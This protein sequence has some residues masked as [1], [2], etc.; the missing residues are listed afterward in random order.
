MFSQWPWRPSA[1]IKKRMPAG[2]FS[3]QA[4]VL[5]VL[6][7]GVA[8]VFWQQL[9]GAAVFIGESDRLNTYLNMRLAEYDALRAY[10]RVPAWN[11]TMF[12]GFSVAALHW[13]N[14]G[15]DPIAY[16]LQL[17]PRD[18]VYQALGYV[19]IALVLAACATAYFYIRDLT[20]ARLPAAIAAVC[21]ALS[22]FGMHRIAQV[23]NAYLTLVLLPAAM[24]AI[25]KVGGGNMIWPF[26]GLTLSMT[27]LAFWGFLQEVAYAFCFLA[28]YALYRAAVSWKCTPRAGLAVLIVFGSAST[29]ALLFAT[30]RLIALGSEFFQLARASSFYYSG[31][32]ELLR[33]LHEGIYGRYFAEGRLIGN[34][35]NFSEGLQLVSSTTVALFV[36]FGALRPSNRSELVAG[37]LL[38]AVIAAFIPIYHIPATA[39][40]PSQELVNIGLYFCILSAIVLLLRVTE[41]Y[42][43]LGATLRKLIPATPR[44]TDTAFHLFAFAV[45]L[46]LILVPEGYFIVY[47]MFGRSD[48]THARLS[49]LGLLPLCSLFAIYVAELKTFPPGHSVARL[50]SRRNVVT[51]LGIVFFAAVLSWVIHGPAVDHLVPKTAFHIRPY[52]PWVIVMP[53]VAVKVVLTTIILTAVVAGFLWK[54]RRS[55]DGRIAAIIVVATFAFVETVIYAHFKVDGPH[56]RTYPVPFGGAFNYMNVPP[57]VMRPPS[58][59]KVK[60]F[61]EKLQV[62]NFRSVLVSPSS[63][64][65]GAITSHISQFWQARMVGGYAFLSKRLAELPWPE[66]VRSLRIIE[67]RSVSDIHPALLSLLNVKYLVLLTPDLYFNMTS[68]TSDKSLNQLTLGSIAHLAEVVNIDGTSFGLI[69]NSLPSL[70]RHFLVEKVTGVQE[71]PRLQGDALE[72]HPHPAS[73][74]QD[75]AG[76]SALA[77]N[78]IDQ[79]TSHSLAEDF[80]GI[81]TFD[82]SGSLDVAYY[83]DMIDV[84]VTPSAR[85]RFLV[86]N[87]RYHPNWHAHAQAEDIPIYPTNIVMMG[88]P[89]PANVDRIE[90][91]F[92]PFSSTRAAYVL[93]LLAILIFLGAI[94]AFRV[95]ERH[96]R[97][98]TL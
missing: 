25:R 77:R 40:W 55:F 47:L 84:R 10:G 23:D 1:A 36:C 82:T 70:P 50:R 12:G 90:L 76:E 48:F 3:S 95:A 85:E 7:G 26:V 56:T 57:A 18:R 13:M 19:S 2:E 14:P 67:L 24:L 46:F 94:G 58:A 31:Y 53:P 93:M 41:P 88:I 28:A 17:F 62:E 89:I 80:R 83:G 35:L 30:P 98:P 21:Y 29:V 33:F 75:R 86:L 38:F 39:A 65:P 87:E 20:G 16:L 43:L 81:E 72:A 52:D 6:L 79:L 42:F 45:T 96:M 4:I 91:R 78:R 97:H 92:D 74:S 66:G 68:E 61:A 60:A 8:L 11:P 5:A 71:T 69:R 37:L 51:A 54:L 63:L 44:P 34:S 22:V 59:E 32:H 73:E 9:V 15:T 27:A 64:Y 49:I